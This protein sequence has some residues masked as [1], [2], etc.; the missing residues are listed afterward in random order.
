MRQKVSKAVDPSLYDREYFLSHCEGY[1]EFLAGGMSSRLKKAAT[2]ISDSETLRILDVGCGR[3]EFVKYMTTKGHT[4]DGIDYSKDAVEIALESAR[5]DLSSDDLRNCRFH[6][7]DSTDMRFDDGTFD[8]CLMLDIIEHLYP[9]ALEKTLNEV[10]RVLKPGGR[11][12]IHTVP[13]KWVIKPARLAMRISR[14]QS[15]EARHV[16]EQSI[17]TLKKAIRRSYRGRIWI[18]REKGFWSFWAQSS[19]RAQSKLITR[20]LRALDLFLDTRIVSSLIDLPPFVFF[21]G[22]DIWGDLVAREKVIE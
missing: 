11:L 8:L 1:T 19:R 9:P 21:C 18:E 2:F 15:E 16:N 14:I 12:I 20:L 10:H 22:T 13:N 17:F 4:C 3:G 5:Q 6:L 7:M